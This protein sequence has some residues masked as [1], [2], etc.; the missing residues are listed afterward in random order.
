MREPMID[1]DVNCRGTVHVL[2]AARRFNP[3]VKIVHVG[4]STQ[5]GRMRSCP[6]DENHAEFPVDIYSANKTAAE[7]YVLIYGSAYKMRT[8]VVRLANTFGPRSNIRTPDFGIMN[9]FVGLA[10]AG[11][12]LSVFGRG[13]QNR[14]AMFIDDTVAALMAAAGNDASNGHV[15]FAVGNRQHTVAEIAAAIVGNIGGNIRFVPWPKDR[16]A[17]EIG[18]AE[19]SNA[20]IRS[21]LNWAPQIDLDAGLRATKEYFAPRLKYYL[22]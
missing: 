6:I 8:T 19:I 4:T 2:E 21:V 16:E 17:I 12:D 20:K 18:D 22:E 14:N 9:Y 1:I 10:F 13:E 15:L 11:K 7:K 3:H 5:I